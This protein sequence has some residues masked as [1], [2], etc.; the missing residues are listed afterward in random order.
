MISNSRLQFL[1]AQS[2][3]F[4]GRLQILMSTVAGGVLTEPANTAQHEGRALYARTVLANPA[5]AAS[6]AAGFVAQSPNVAN[7]ITM[8]D[9]G[10]RTSVDD[11]ALFAGVSALWNQLAGVG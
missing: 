1:L 5:H 2:D 3:V 11:N 9:E 8:E 7:T 4:R 10:P 6:V